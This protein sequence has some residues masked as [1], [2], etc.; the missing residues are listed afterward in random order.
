MK[1][2][3]SDDQKLKLAERYL[4]VDSCRDFPPSDQHKVVAD[5]ENY[6]WCMPVE[7]YLKDGPPKWARETTAVQKDKLFQYTKTGS[8]VA[9]VVKRLLLSKASGVPNN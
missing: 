9:K 8:P 1:L 5:L 7:N 6:H 4:A 2:E 3:I